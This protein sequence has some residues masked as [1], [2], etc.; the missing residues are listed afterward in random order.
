[1]KSVRNNNRHYPELRPGNPSVRC[2][3]WLSEDDGL[4]VV[5]RNQPVDAGRSGDDAAED[6]E[7]LSGIKR[8]VVFCYSPGVTLLDRSC[9]W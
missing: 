1:L 6:V 8:A 5:D 4:L 2:V 3:A 9:V 7:D